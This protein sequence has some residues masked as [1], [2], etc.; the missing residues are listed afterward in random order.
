MVSTL[1]RVFQTVGGP[2]PNTQPNMHLPM[3]NELYVSL[4]NYYHRTSQ[5]QRK[6]QLMIW[7][8]GIPELTALSS[9][10]ARDIVSEF[11]FEPLAGRSNKDVER[12]NE[13]SIKTQ[14][15]KIK[16]SQ[17]IDRLI[18]G[19]SFGW[20]G[21]ISKE[22]ADKFENSA[23]KFL[24]KYEG[25]LK[26]NK[27]MT[28]I[29]PYEG[30]S[31]YSPEIDEA[32]R[33]PRLYRYLPSTTMEIIFNKYDIIEYVQRVAQ[34]FE[35]YNPKEIIHGTFMDV[36][37]KVSGF[38]PVESVIVQLELLRFMWGNMLSIQK[39]GGHPDKIITL[40]DMKDVSSPSYKRIE[41][42]L[43]KYKLVENKHGN[44]LFTGKVNVT[45]LQQMESMQFKD[46]GL[47]ITGLIAM[48]WGIPRSSIPYIVDGTNTKDDTG[49]N[50]E[51]G[52]WDNIQYSQTIDA[53]IDNTQLW[54]PFF[55]VKMVYDKKYIQKD[56]QEE[57]AKQ[58]KYNNIKLG[59]EILQSSGKQLKGE[60]LLKLFG[61]ADSDVEE[62]EVLMDPNSTL[63]EQVSQSDMKPEG[64]Q[65]ISK[66]KR[67]EQNST[68]ASRGKPTGVGKEVRRNIF[69]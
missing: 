28:L 3:L 50:S 61:L 20:I 11:H 21:K 44:M 69:Y 9:K 12:A 49:G 42:Q 2:A 27:A 7:Y 48:Q 10:V 17:V 32:L 24:N 22:K 63:N 45:E 33:R 46:M 54:M 15:R 66:R 29:D 23:L 40:E 1:S 36:D 26:E 34:Q 6:K 19:E 18:T 62:A 65:N 25:S 16:Y 67:D 41:E 53:E 56:V 58:L 5:I 55:G 68:I 43:R 47:Y 59:N 37:G 39:N 8:K 57:T 60:T 51:R 38:T 31:S 35:Q 30:I 52:Y 64:Q 13:F 4:S 14:Y